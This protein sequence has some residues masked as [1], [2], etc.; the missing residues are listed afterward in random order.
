MDRIANGR[1]ECLYI[2]ENGTSKAPFFGRRK[3][4]QQ[5]IKQ[6]NQREIVHADRA[7][8]RMA[9]QASE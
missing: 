1:L 3:D 7:Y 8:L 9:G 6:A 5:L 2:W 4:L